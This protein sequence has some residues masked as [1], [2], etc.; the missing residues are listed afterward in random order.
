MK[1]A[2]HPRRSRRAVPA[3]ERERIPPEVRLAALRA[4]HKV[5]PGTRQHPRAAE[6]VPLI[7]AGATVNDLCVALDIELDT[8]AAL[9]F[10]LAGS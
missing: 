1:K 8:A 9:L 2:K 4:L 6:A 10:R 3:G 5:R 7:L